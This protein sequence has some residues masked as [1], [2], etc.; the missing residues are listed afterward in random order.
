MASQTQNSK[1]ESCFQDSF[2]FIE[3]NGTPALCP[4][5]EKNSQL[6]SHD[7]PAR[8]KSVQPRK[9]SFLMSKLNR[10]NEN[11]DISCSKHNQEVS[12]FC[13]LDKCFLCKI[14]LI[15]HA[16]HSD[17]IS[18]DFVIEKTIKDTEVIHQQLRDIRDFFDGQLLELENIVEQKKIDSRRLETY[19]MKSSAILTN[20]QLMNSVKQPYR[21]SKSDQ[22]KSFFCNNESN[23]FRSV[24]ADLHSG[25]Q[26]SS[27]A[28]NTK[29]GQAEKGNVLSPRQSANSNSNVCLNNGLGLDIWQSAVMGWPKKMLENSISTSF[30]ISSNSS[31]LKKR[32]QEVYV[33]S[34]F[35]R[36]PVAQLL[37]RASKND[38]KA[39][40]FHQKCD[41]KFPLLMIFQSTDDKI[42]G[43]YVSQSF[44]STGG[45]KEAP[46]SF[47][48]SISQNA[49]MDLCKNFQN[50]IYCHSFYGPTFGC[51]YDL[52]VPCGANKREC[53]SRLG[54][55][56]ALP[57]NTRVN[58][59]EAGEFL[60][61]KQK[62]LLKDYE[63]FHLDFDVFE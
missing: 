51:G 54:Y 26:K 18:K 56:Y 53:S 21:F 49:K 44:E 7:L 57:P 5:P 23:I 30:D 19:F 59:K 3:G 17:Q 52:F 20:Q 58:S 37:Y 29:R 28:Q 34:L 4:N 31:I 16:I 10:W 25:I 50:A 12:A 62:F 11:M 60:A 61:G 36:L 2:Q 55:T 6:R 24:D 42:F 46:G 8:N 47:L 15:E 38:F 22:E 9:V 40:S 35:T 27:Q 1:F 33:R 41:G 32:S 48:F 63:V 45:F 14:C 43:A 39:E 13:H